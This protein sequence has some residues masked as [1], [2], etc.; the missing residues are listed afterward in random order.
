MTITNEN[1]RND[2]TA[3]GIATE[4]DF[5][6]KILD[7]TQ[8]QVVV[9][10]LD[11]VETILELTT[12]YT[13]SLDADTGLGTITLNDPVTSGYAITLLRNMDFEQNTA[14]Q[15]QGTSQFPGASHEKALDKVTLLALQLKE[16]LNRSFILPKTSQL[17]GIEIPVNTNTSGKAIIVNAAG[18]GLD[19]KDLADISAAAFSDLGLELVA[20]ETAAAIRVLADAQQLNANLTALA[21]LTGAANK[22]PYFTGAG[23]LGLLTKGYQLKG[24]Q[25]F[26][27]SG[28]WTKPTG[29]LAAA[30]EVFGG[31]G[32][33]GSALN[34]ASIA[35][36]AGG[37]GYSYKFITSGLGATETVTVGPGGSGGLATQNGGNGG[38]SSFGGHCSAT[39]GTG[40]KNTQ[41]SG[42]GN[43]GSGSGGDLNL[44]G[45]SG[46]AGYTISLH[47]DGGGAPRGGGTAAGAIG[48]TGGTGKNYGGGG[49]ASGTAI[50]GGNGASGAII[51]YEYY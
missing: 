35:T 6:F 11:D 1:S 48:G 8:V 5:T 37:G 10:D 39:G 13:V 27:S 3:N 32:Q 41:G 47:G 17:S 46:N 15:N 40:G 24:V 42:I 28:T 20:A 21:G 18:D 36:G 44:Q 31:G 14:Y 23:A 7:E 2:Y 30:V 34:G 26:T 45:S 50:P 51:V 4:Y 29:C 16:I 43:S 9:A 25:V 12:D 33:G 38:T 19:V 49:G 22:I